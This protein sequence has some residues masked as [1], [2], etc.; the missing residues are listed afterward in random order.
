MCRS[1]ASWATFPTQHR[2]A[3]SSTPSTATTALKASLPIPLPRTFSNIPPGVSLITQ[4]FYALVFCTRYLNLFTYPP[5]ASYWNFVLKIF[6]ITSS[7]Y[8]LF[9]MTR[10]YA[11]T[12]EREKAWKMG[13]WCLAGS[14]VLTPIMVLIFRPAGRRGFTEVRVLLLIL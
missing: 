10:V 4:A 2:Y 8:I 3:S 12:R 5:S 6:Y 1:S 9:L 13:M 7:F 14:I 11:R